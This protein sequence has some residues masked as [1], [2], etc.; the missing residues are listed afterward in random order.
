MIKNVANKKACLC[1]KPFHRISEFYTTWYCI[2]FGISW[3]LCM[4]SF[5]YVFIVFSQDC[6]QNIRKPQNCKIN[7][8]FF[9]EKIQ[10]LH[11]L[12]INK[13][14]CFIPLIAS[15]WKMFLLKLSTYSYIISHKS[16]ISHSLHQ[17]CSKT[18]CSYLQPSAP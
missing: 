1:M 4:H 18:N 17:L 11:E 8:I 14:P 2:W 6:L 13:H 15:W 5:L 3:V 9:V 16:R 7:T 10:G 12:F